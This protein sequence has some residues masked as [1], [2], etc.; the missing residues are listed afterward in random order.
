MTTGHVFIATSLDGFI[1]R[2]DGA[3]DWLMK[4][5]TE[6]E[7][8]GYDAFM[9]SVDGV[10][11][12]RGSF[13]KVLTFDPWPYDKPVIVMSSSLGETDIPAPLRSKVRLSRLTPR[14]LM[15]DLAG[16]GWKRAYIDGGML[17]RSFLRDGLIS[18]MTLTR[19]PVLIGQGRPLFGN[20]TRDIDLE[21]ISTRNFPSGLVTSEYRVR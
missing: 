6:S 4:H 1:A 5:E 19:V 3:L 10:V 11:M 17:I 21:H 13:E 2:N 7:D 20:L 12:G 9:A 16:Q 14:A 18:D 15:Q 8:H